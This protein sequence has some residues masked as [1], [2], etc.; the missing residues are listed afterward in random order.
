MN[1]QSR[2]FR[3]FDS[4]PWKTTGLAE[5]FHHIKLTS[6]CLAPS[7]LAGEPRILPAPSHSLQESCGRSPL[8]KLLLSQQRCLCSSASSLDFLQ[9]WPS[10]AL[11]QDFQKLLK[12]NILSLPPSR[13]SFI[14]LPPAQL[15]FSLSQLAIS[16]LWYEFWMTLRSCKQMGAVDQT[17]Q[18]QGKT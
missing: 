2:A 17:T 3:K 12:T 11:F 13:N 6:F 18:W 7:T 8:P 5:K 16:L 9:L 15:Q 1:C 4:G 14:T 10:S